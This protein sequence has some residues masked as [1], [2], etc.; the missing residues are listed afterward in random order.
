MD[1]SIM[2]PNPDS[3]G[4]EIL[5]KA[6]FRYYFRKILRVDNTDGYFLLHWRS[7]A[8]T[9]EEG[10]YVLLKCWD[11]DGKT[12]DS[13]PAS[14]ENG[15]FHDLFNREANWVINPSVILGWT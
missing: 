6:V 3:L 8:D 13:C 7:P 1:A 10:S 4:A 14:Y 15:Q 9:P 11:T 5:Q 12:V 2:P